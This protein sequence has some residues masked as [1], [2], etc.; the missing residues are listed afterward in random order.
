MIKRHI[1]TIAVALIICSCKKGPDTS[2]YPKT[3]YMP[4]R[5][6]AT[7]AQA[8]LAQGISARVNIGFDSYSGVVKFTGFE[9]AAGTG[10]QYDIRAKALFQKPLSG[11]TLPVSS[12]MDTTLN[13]PVSVTGQYILHFYGA[14]QLVESDTV[15]V[16]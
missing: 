6:A 3:G 12:G 11:I 4:I 10:R 8:T 2:G 14:T 15:I 1:W 13:I 16:N 5:A 9:A 7:S